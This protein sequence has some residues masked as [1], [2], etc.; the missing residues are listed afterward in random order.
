[1]RIQTII[2]VD[3]KK[4]KTPTY[5]SWQCMKARCSR[6]SNHKDHKNYSG[7]G[8]KVHP[9]WGG[10][11]GYQNFY[12][13]MGERPSGCTLDRIDSD[14]HYEPSNCKWSTKLEQN[15]NRRKKHQLGFPAKPSNF[16]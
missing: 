16:P 8:V 5:T 15:S 10:L 3:G 4:K 12:R 7:R 6:P 1:M 9:R 13:D 11:D 14:G 2:W